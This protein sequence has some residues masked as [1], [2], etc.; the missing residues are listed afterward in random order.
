[1]S[2]NDVIVERISSNLVDFTPFEV[3]I[4]ATGIIEIKSMDLIKKIAGRWALNV[5]R[6]NENF[7]CVSLFWFNGITLNQRFD[8]ELNHIL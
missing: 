8:S 4:H 1:M 6:G 7:T 3:V 5:Y 2:E